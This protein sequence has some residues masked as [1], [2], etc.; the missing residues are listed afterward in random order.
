MAGKDIGSLAAFLI[1]GLIVAI[2]GF[3]Q[4]AYAGASTTPSAA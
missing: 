4:T 2:T 3:L 1:M